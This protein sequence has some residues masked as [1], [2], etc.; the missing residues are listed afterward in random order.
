MEVC[1]VYARTGVTYRDIQPVKE[2][3]ARLLLGD[4]KEALKTIADNSIDLIVTSPP[5]ADRRS[6]TYGGIRPDDYVE[7]F[8]PITAELLRVMKPS[9]IFIL[10]I[11]ERVV[12]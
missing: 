11:K 1:Q 8:L 7:W 12:E 4:C 9:G 6:K 2:I 3:T 5:Y 10:N